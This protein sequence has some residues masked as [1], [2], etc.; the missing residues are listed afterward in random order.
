MQLPKVS[1][2]LLG[3]LVAACEAARGHHVRHDKLFQPRYLNQTTS[4]SYITVYPTPAPTSPSTPVSPT[5]PE[6]ETEG[7]SEAVT[8]TS[9]VGTVTTTSVITTTIYKTSTRTETV[10]ETLSPGAD[11]TDIS[12]ATETDNV[13][14][15]GV[16]T[17]LTSTTTLTYTV[18][19]VPTSATA[20][21]GSGSG[22]VGC[23]SPATVTITE[24][25]TVTVTAL[26]SATYTEPKNNHH[27]A[28]LPEQTDRPSHPHHPPHRPGHGHGHGH[29][30]GD[31]DKDEDE[32][33]GNGPVPTSTST[34]TPPSALYP[35]VPPNNG[36]IPG[37]GSG[38]AKPTGFVTSRLPFPTQR[39]RRGI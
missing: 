10:Y 34:P 19:P 15:S 38:V 32:D 9:T 36:T 18:R 25:F 24:S 23:E 14:S 4:T 29:G 39:H 1:V 30:D 21:D 16:D 12:T 22:T 5:P 33:N 17:T 20:S 28:T 11:N 6:Y 31:G 7:P 35:T 27:V 13:P 8:V 37:Y 26:P 2:A 3:A